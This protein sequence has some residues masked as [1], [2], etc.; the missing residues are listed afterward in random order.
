LFRYRADLEN[1][2][3]ITDFR[4][5]QMHTLSLSPDKS[6]VSFIRSKVTSPQPAEM[7]C[8]YDLLDQRLIK[9]PVSVRSAVWTADGT[10]IACTARSLHRGTIGEGRWV[11]LIDAS[12]GKIVS[13]KRVS[14]HYDVAS[15]NTCRV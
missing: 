5:A 15:E 4:D 11:I 14:E 7:L 6:K 13:G 3:R 8:I 2:L 1:V 12:T 10:H 9:I